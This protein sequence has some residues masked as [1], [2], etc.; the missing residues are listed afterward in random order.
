MRATQAPPDHRTLRRALADASEH[1]RT[2]PLADDTALRVREVACTALA[3]LSAG[4][5][6]DCDPDRAQLLAPLVADDIAR[7]Q[8]LLEDH[9]AIGAAR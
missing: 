8:R 9:A 4:L 1:L 5:L 7:I 2:L 6:G 3:A